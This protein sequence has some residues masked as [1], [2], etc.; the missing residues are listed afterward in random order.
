MRFISIVM[1]VTLAGVMAPAA[2]FSGPAFGEDAQAEAAFHYKQGVALFKEQKYDM[3]LAEFLK[4]Y[5][6]KPT[7]KLRINI[8]ICYY[9]L[10]RFLDARKELLA[11][12]EEG[13]DQVAADKKEQAENLLDQI[14][15]LTAEIQVDVN[16]VGAEVFVDGE[17]AG[18]TPL[19]DPLAVVTG[20]HKIRVTAEGSEPIVKEVTVAGGDKKKLVF[21]FGPQTGKAPPKEKVEKAPVKETQKVEKNS[22]EDAAQEKKPGA[23]ALAIGGYA[24]AGL[25]AG[26]LVAGAVT[27]GLALSLSKDLEKKCAGNECPPAQHDDVDRMNAMAMASTVLLAVGGAAAATGIALIIVGTVKGRKLEKQKNVSLAIL[28]PGGASLTFE[29]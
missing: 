22:G 6:L 12:L 11:Y 16:V 7:W 4:S 9:N 3:A 10:D 2:I 18:E 25:G 15:S 17:P 13:G 1:L 5:E 8:G 24:A 28:P 27:G 26:L 29:F 19:G 23:R 14:A 21:E 20:I